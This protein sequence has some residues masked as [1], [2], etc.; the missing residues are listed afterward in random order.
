MA[1]R[2]RN[3]NIVGIKHGQSF[4]SMKESPLIAQ[5]GVFWIVPP[6]DLHVQERACACL[7]ADA[8]VHF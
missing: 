1:V 2:A 7:A 6:I 4:F 8:C 3:Q 5:Q